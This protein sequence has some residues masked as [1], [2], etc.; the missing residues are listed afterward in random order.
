[1]TIRTASQM[2]HFEQ[3]VAE[4]LYE[5]DTL[6]ARSKGGASTPLPSNESVDKIAVFDAM[7]KALRP[8]EAGRR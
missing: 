1:M 8:D 4:T 3:V 7:N 2:R 6:A 5:L